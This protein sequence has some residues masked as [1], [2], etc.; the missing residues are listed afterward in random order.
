MT[1]RLIFLAPRGLSAK[2]PEQSNLY[3]GLSPPPKVVGCYHLRCRSPG[4]NRRLNPGID[5]FRVDRNIFK[6]VRGTD[7]PAHLVPRGACC[8]GPTRFAN[9]RLRQRPQSVIVCNFQ[10]CPVKLSVL[11]ENN[12]LGR[13]IL[14]FREDSASL[15]LDRINGFGPQT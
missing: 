7:D 1:P 3:A 10:N 14:A 13:R 12:R 5:Q 15:E 6:F 11:H 2:I 9:R 4:V 8:D